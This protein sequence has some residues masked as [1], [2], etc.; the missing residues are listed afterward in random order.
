MEQLNT[1]EWQK[2]SLCLEKHGIKKCKK[3]AIHT[4]NYAK[5][6][7]RGVGDL[8]ICAVRDIEHMAP[9]QHMYW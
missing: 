1:T 3:S 6:F 8:Y 9:T 7:S 2:A 5:R 4:I